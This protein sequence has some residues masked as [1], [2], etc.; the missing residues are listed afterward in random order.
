MGGTST[1]NGMLYG[2]GN[3]KDYDTWAKLG[4]PGWSYKEVLPFFLKSED[5]RDKDVSSLSNKN[6]CKNH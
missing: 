4:N 2:R 3:K 1:I 6:Y 5:N